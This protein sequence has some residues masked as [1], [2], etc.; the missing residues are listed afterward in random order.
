[1]QS[2]PLLQKEAIILHRIDKSH[3]IKPTVISPTLTST[4]QTQPEYP[5]PILRKA[6]RS[7]QRLARPERRVLPVYRNKAVQRVMQWSEYASL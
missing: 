3:S 5:L 6:L 7:P 2:Q 4:S 1:M